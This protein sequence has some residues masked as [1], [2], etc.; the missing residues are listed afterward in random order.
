MERVVIVGAGPAGLTAAYE[1]LKKSKKFEVI[2]LEEGKQVGGISKTV[3]YNGNRMDIGGHRFF[4][5][6]NEVMALWQEILP[7]G[8][9]KKEKVLLERKRVSRIYY[10]KKFFDY[11]VNLSFK[12]IK[13]L[14]NF[15]RL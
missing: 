13:N 5:K 1:L 12:T 2:V 7:L 11:P 10:N 6:D 15:T 4:T 9:E 8:S 14:F 3:C